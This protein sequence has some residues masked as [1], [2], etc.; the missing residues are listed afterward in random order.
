MTTTLRFPK[1]DQ[2]FTC[3]RVDDFEGFLRA[4]EGRETIDLSE[5][6]LRGVDL[7][8]ID[9]DRV[10][11]RGAYLRE[12]DLRGLDLTRVDLEGCSMLHAKVSGVRF[13]TGLSAAEIRMSIE[14]GTRLRP[15]S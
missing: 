13:P 7:R 15:G 6:D 1:D 5:T 4:T 8:R 14:L 9:V 2:A 10:I 11:L 3:L 12:A